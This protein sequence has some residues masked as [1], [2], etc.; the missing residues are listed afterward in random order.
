MRY[1][2][3]SREKDSI[4]VKL[5]KPRPDGKF[6]GQMFN[7]AKMPITINRYYEIMGID[8]ETHVPTRKELERLGMKDVADMLDKRAEEKSKTSQKSAGKSKK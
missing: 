5:M 8:P 6:K 4:P 1:S 3:L 2:F 7:L